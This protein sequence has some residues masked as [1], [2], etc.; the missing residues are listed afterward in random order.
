MCNWVGPKLLCAKRSFSLA[1]TPFL[2]TVSTLINSPMSEVN[3]PQLPRPR[4]GS[5]R[6]KL[7][8]ISAFPLLAIAT[9]AATLT[10]INVSDSGPGSF[11]QAI[12]DANATNGLDT[13][14]FQIPGAGIHTIAPASALP[15][16]TDPAIIDATTQPGFLGLPLIELNG[17]GAGGNA[18]IR[19]LAGGS[20]V[21]GLAVNR[22]GA[23]GIRI[24][25]PGT[26]SIQGNFLG[27]DP[28][29][30]I[31]RPNA[32]NGILVNASFGNVIGGT[33]PGD[34]NLI[35]GNADTG[36]YLLNGGANI[37]QGNYIG[38]TPLGTVDL[39][40]VNNGIAIYN[41]AANTI[42]GTT[43]AARNIVSGNDGSG[44]YVFGSGS[45]GNVIQGNFL[46]TD[47]TGLLALSNTFDGISIQGAIGNSI[48]GTNP[49]EGNL[50]SGNGKAGVFLYGPGVVGNSV[51][52]NLVGTDASGRLALGNGLAGVTILAGI[53]NLIGGPAASARNVIAANKQDGIFI[54]TNSAAN[55]VAAN[56]IGVDATGTNALPN[57]FNGISLNAANSNLI[58]GTTA[59]TRNVI[60]GNANNGLHLYFGSTGNLAQGN[61]IG[62]DMTGNIA[63]TNKFSGVRLESPGNTIGIGNIISGNASNGVYLV[64]S[65]AAS[66]VI[67][68]NFIGTIASGTAALP[69]GLAGIGV[70]DAPGNTIG[71]PGAGN[72]ISGNRDAGIY[73][74]GT[75]ATG[76]RI[77]ANIIGADVTGTV[78]MGNIRWGI[79]LDRASSNLIGGPDPA[80]RNIIS[81][82]GT[83][84]LFFTNS[85]WNT[86]QG[87]YI[88]AA[89][90]GIS[91]M[92]NGY[93]LAGFHAVEV[94][95]GSYSNTFGGATIAAGNRIAFAPFLSGIYYAGL[96]MRD[97]SSTNNP[98]R[99]NQFFSNAGLSIDLGAY[100]VTS[101]DPCDADSGANQ[102]QNYPD[103]AVAVSGSGTAVRGTLSSKSFGTYLLQ[104]Y[105][106]PVC[107]S[108]GHGEGQIF[109]GEK[110]VTTTASCDTNFTAFFAAPTPVGY[111]I[112]ATATDLSNN[113]SEFSAC[114]PVLAVPALKINSA[115]AQQVSLSWTNTPA[116]FVLKQTD[117]LSPPIQWISVTNTPV[118]SNGEFSITLP[119]EPTNRFFL[120]SFE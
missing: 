62:P 3:P 69:N 89:A 60:S 59:A 80:A 49:G 11:R 7:L 56:F 63:L 61:Y 37:V 64:G 68:G 85:S 107:G 28:T 53:S 21:R 75:G 102:L 81:G 24:D 46:G 114:V 5:S 26:N 76:E 95:I 36:V 13:I 103:L 70:S 99:C 20:V 101:N 30:L 116:G 52:G 87:N 14:I 34:R 6:A 74:I 77:Q 94:H 41:S 27:T 97:A 58:G 55:T 78:P 117:S 93:T 112:A 40:N 65:V 82:N 22:C 32:Q 66:N 67:Q 29:G 84:G 39:G 38:T 47:V 25:G 90:D 16:I 79:Y 73:L 15:P 118:N 31:A 83:W 110:M 44:I 119:V 113:T 43:P 51:Q 45:I 48:G 9:H 92:G 1:T 17:T 57:L 96:R 111:S 33:N 86:I 35:S 88:G 12:T 104:F 72:V 10:V 18:G 115:S 105:A 91:A 109:L 8:L 108:Q 100:L 2:D 23:E 71:A 54:T 42:G 19:L 50:I 120:L 106:N 4:F 98:V